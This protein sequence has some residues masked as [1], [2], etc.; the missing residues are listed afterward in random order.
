MEKVFKK[1]EILFTIL[2]II[3]YVVVNSY[4]M[5]NFG[6]TSLQ[7]VIVNTI[8]SIVY[9]ITYIALFM[10]MLRSFAG[11]FAIIDGKGVNDN[12]DPLLRNTY[13]AQTFVF[14]LCFAIMII[15]RY[16]NRN[17]VRKEP[18]IYRRR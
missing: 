7:S 6:Y 13:I 9:V 5:Q 8:L 4:L 1:H 12:I 15:E 16:T 11:L 17:I 3:I 10:G 18:S 2:L 14:L